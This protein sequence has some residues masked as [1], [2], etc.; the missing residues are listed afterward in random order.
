MSWNHGRMTTTYFL[1]GVCCW[2]KLPVQAKT[3]IPAPFWSPWPCSCLTGG[4]ASERG[5][6]SLPG[7]Q[8]QRE[9]LSSGQP[10]IAGGANCPLLPLLPLM[11][12]ASLFLFHQVSLQ[13][14]GGGNRRLHQF[15]PHFPSPRPPR[16]PKPLSTSK[17]SHFWRPLV[18]LLVVRPT[19]LRY[20]RTK[21]L[22][23]SC[24]CNQPEA[25]LGSLPS[26]SRYSALN[27]T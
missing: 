24:T 4:G 22:L 16:P 9:L 12:I 19:Y 5:G 6:A 25:P 23:L 13:S 26:S 10:L 8:S 11:M 2:M 1:C 17:E 18:L 20:L 7:F 14:G 21:R 15:H 3:F 27:L